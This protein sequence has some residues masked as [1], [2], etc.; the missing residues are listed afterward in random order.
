MA[1]VAYTTGAPITDVTGLESFLNLKAFRIEGEDFTSVTLAPL[2]SLTFFS[3]WR[4]P[5]TSIDLSH[6]KALTMVGLSETNLTTVDMS[7]LTNLVEFDGQQSSIPLPYQT[8]L[9]NAVTVSGW[10][11]IK[12]PQS[13]NFLRIY[14]SDNSTLTSIDLN[15]VKNSLQ[16]FYATDTGLTSIDF[17]GA[18]NLTRVGLNLDANLTSVKMG[19]AT[20]RTLFTANDPMLHTILVPTATLGYW[21]TQ[22]TSMLA[23]LAC[24]AGTGPSGCTPG[25]PVWVDTT[26]GPGIFVGY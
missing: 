23:A 22:Y 14:I 2:Q 18:N 25:T 21:D 1:K 8:G 24:Q 16:E 3:F 11:N 5:L 20:P 15:P 12:L 10:T 26:Y 19:T 4:E 17:T 9:N 13:P 7:A 6:N